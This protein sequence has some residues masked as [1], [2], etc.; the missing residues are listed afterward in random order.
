MVRKCKT[1][2][3]N[4]AASE[5]TYCCVGCNQHMHL[6]TQGT[7]L[8][9]VAING[10]KELDNNCMLMCNTCLDNG[11]RDVVIRCRAQTKV[12]SVISDL[13]IYEKL[14]NL[15]NKFSEFVD[16]KLAN[17]ISKSCD[18]IEQNYAKVTAKTLEKAASVVA[19]SNSKTKVKSE[20]LNKL[21][22]T[23]ER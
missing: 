4:I 2:K 14:S 16:S 23:R 1:C 5:K 22:N 9:N 3:N 19:S 6:I 11:E 8:S 7:A 15:E 13:K 21:Q 20:D 12:E 10:I 18:K 17:L